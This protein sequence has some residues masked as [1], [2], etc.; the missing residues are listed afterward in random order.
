MDINPARNRQTVD[1]LYF[2]LGHELYV[3]VRRW[4]GTVRLSLAQY[5]R[6]MVMS[7]PRKPLV[8]KKTIRMSIQQLGKMCKYKDRIAEAVRHQEAN[9][10]RDFASTRWTPYYVDRQQQ[11]RDTS[12]CVNVMQIPRWADDVAG[13]GVGAATTQTTAEEEASTSRK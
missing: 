9:A 13:G 6:S 7:G 8:T 3:E 1:P 12:D 2:P 11:Q 10:D 4:R 5:D